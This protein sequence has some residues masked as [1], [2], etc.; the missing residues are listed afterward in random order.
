[1][2][3]FACASGFYSTLCRRQHSPASRYANS[4]RAINGSPAFAPTPLA[5]GLNVGTSHSW[6]GRV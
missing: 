2:I 5:L 4:A 1:M 6:P 3:T